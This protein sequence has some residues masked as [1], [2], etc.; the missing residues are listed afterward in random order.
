MQAY[1]AAIA[2][3]SN[4]VFNL[5][6]FDEFMEI[7]G[8]YKKLSSELNNNVTYRIDSITN[9]YYFVPIDEKN[10]ETDEENAV[11][12]ASGIVIGYILDGYKFEQLSSEQQEKVRRLV[13]IRILGAEKELKKIKGFSDNLF[14]SDEPEVREEAI[15]QLVSFDLMNL[16]KEDGYIVLMGEYSATAKF[17][18]LHLYDMGQKVK[19]E[20][21]DN[22]LRLITLLWAVSPTA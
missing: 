5:S 15:K 22:S 2:D 11:K 3:S 17:K 13:D 9:P 18:Y 14:L 1:L 21:I 16:R 20:S 8:F 12:N 7:F 10:I 4:L 6:Q 19:L